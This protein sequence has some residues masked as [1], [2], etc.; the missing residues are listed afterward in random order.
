M[1]VDLPANFVSSLN[2]YVTI[3]QETG[4]LSLGDTQLEQWYQDRK[5]EAIN[6]AEC[7]AAN[8]AHCDQLE[9][10]L[11]AVNKEKD[12]IKALLEVAEREYALPAESER[13]KKKLDADI[14]QQSYKLVSC[15]EDVLFRT[16]C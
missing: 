9:Q 12:S 16:R 6:V 5:L 8:R 13:S 4:L 11:A 2:E 14:A 3:Q 1:D 7:L 15:Y 10:R